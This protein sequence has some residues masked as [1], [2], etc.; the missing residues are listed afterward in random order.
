MLGIFD[1]GEIA[2]Q[3]MLQWRPQTE[4]NL[5]LLRLDISQNF[6]SYFPLYYN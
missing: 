1:T 6:I 4:E 2:S 3:Y 5:I